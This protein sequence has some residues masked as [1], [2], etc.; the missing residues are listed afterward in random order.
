MAVTMANQGG[1]VVV[2]E[3]SGFGRR[4]DWGAVFAGAAIAIASIFF[5]LSLG[6]GV[7]L[8]L[9]SAKG[10]VEPRFLTLGA[11][12][13]LAAQT[14]GLAIGGHFTGRLIG[15]AIETNRAEEFR[16]ITHGL[17][18]WAF[19][20]IV[21]VA[22]VIVSGWVAAGSASNL[23]AMTGGASATAESVTPNVANYWADMLFRPSAADQHASLAGEQYAQADTG[24]QTDAQPEENP[25]EIQPMQNNLPNGG[26]PPPNAPASAQ[27][28]PS[29]PQGVSPTT[30]NS[31]IQPATPR[32][33]QVIEIPQNGATDQGE[34]N[35]AINVPVQTGPRN[36]AADKAEVARI[37]EVGMANGGTLSTY[38]KQRIANLIAMDTDA[39]GEATRRVNDAVSTIRSDEMRTAEFARKT[40][41]NTSL[42]I[43]LALLFG[44]VVTA[45]AAVSARWEDDAIAA[46][47]R[48]PG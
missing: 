4:F 1:V 7:G 5:L 18:V 19:A 15:P 6:S 47:R 26:T 31:D 35:G 27:A 9:V 24:T 48:E 12:Y 20:V 39:G 33:S 46:G 41:R 16:A 40:L 10:I 36:V 22:I 25:P 8:S 43:A 28:A 3:E 37:L 29:S 32:R 11:I 42:W 17:V 14:F 44:A 30:S 13:F 45:M 23:A 34:Q 38:D 2:E 21:T